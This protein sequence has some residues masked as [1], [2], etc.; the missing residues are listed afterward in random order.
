M[1]RCLD[2]RALLRMYTHDGSAAEQSHLRLCT[3]CTEHY[4]QLVGDLETIGHAL[5]TPPPAAVS[6]RALPARMSWVPAGIAGAALAVVMLNFAWVRHSSPVQVATRLHNV[7]AFA[8][9]LS[10]AL[11]ATSDASAFVPLAEE[12]P[13][14]EAALNAGQPCTQ[15]QFFRGACTDQ[16]S[17]L[18]I[19]DE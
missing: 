14:L 2:E 19:E 8:G 10:D 16:F 18:M 11:F 4:D 1:N 13:Y 3:E 6:R 17:A 7:S 15:D 5:A 9:D 12:A